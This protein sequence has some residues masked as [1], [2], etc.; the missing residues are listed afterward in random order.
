MNN[1]LI[2]LLLSPRQNQSNLTGGVEVIDGGPLLAY[3]KSK[4]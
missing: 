2:L 4:R 1:D 3:E